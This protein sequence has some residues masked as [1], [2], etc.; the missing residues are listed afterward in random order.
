MAS[1]CKMTEEVVQEAEEVLVKEA[2]VVGNG[3]E[4]MTGGKMW[5]PR[6]QLV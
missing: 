5:T 3:A 4:L 6:A 2:L 1:R